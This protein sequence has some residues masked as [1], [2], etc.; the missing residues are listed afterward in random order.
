VL[1][2]KVEPV[3]V[4]KVVSFWDLLVLD[5]FRVFVLLLPELGLLKGLLELFV[6]EI[7]KS[8]S[9]NGRIGFNEFL[10]S[11]LSEAEGVL[12]AVLA[13]ERVGLLVL[14]D[15]G[16]PADVHAVDFRDQQVHL[17]TWSVLQMQVS[18]LR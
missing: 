13:V 9:S 11:D 1:A 14:A 5:V 8:A 6:A 10:I 2:G 12:V 4:S 18:S 15:I 17:V 7:T 3:D 16:L